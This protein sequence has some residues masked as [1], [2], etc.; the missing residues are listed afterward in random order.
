MSQNSSFFQQDPT[1]KQTMVEKSIAAQKIAYCPYS[2]FHVGACI[3][4]TNGKFYTG[5]NVENQSY[6]LTICAERCAV[7]KMVSDECKSIKAVVV[8]TN[9]GVTPCGACRQV[10]QEFA[11]ENS[12]DFPIL[13]VNSESGSSIE[14]SMKELLPNAV[15]LHFLKSEQ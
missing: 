3:L 6:G 12:K 5:C 13:I 7:F 2:K 9:I 1:L 14:S 11:D 10:L 4:G 15:D 8:S